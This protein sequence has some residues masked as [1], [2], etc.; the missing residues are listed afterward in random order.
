MIRFRQYFLSFHT[1]LN[2]RV[3][4]GSENRDLPRNFMKDG[5]FLLR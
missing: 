2:Y 3:S 5:N 1:V 4:I